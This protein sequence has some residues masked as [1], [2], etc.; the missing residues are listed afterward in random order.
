MKPICV[1]C[2]RFFRMKKSGVYFTEGMPVGPD[3]AEPGTTDPDKWKPYKIWSGDRWQ[4]DGCGAVIISGCGLQPVSEHYQPDFAH[5]MQ[6]LKAD[7]FQVND[8]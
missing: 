6:S 5:Y 3:R 1:P 4:C 8:C 7:Q 2:H